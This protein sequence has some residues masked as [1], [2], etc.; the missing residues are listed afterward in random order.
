MK[1]AMITP[2]YKVDVRGGGELSLQ[3]LVEALRNQGISVVVFSGDKLFPKIKDTLKLNTA[4]YKYLKNQ[5]LADMIFT[6]LIICP[7]YL[8]LEGLLKNIT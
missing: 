7:Y 4:M 1:I 2:R 5:L 3:L 6:T 8:Q